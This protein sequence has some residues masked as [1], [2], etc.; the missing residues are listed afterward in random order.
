MILASL[1]GLGCFARSG[2]RINNKAETNLI[3]GITYPK[4]DM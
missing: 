3:D 2:Q 4:L 1:L